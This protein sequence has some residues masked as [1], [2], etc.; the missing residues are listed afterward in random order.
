MP[1]MHQEKYLTNLNP[2]S[3]IPMD[4]LSKIALLHGFHLDSSLVLITIS[5]PQNYLA[6]D[7]LTVS[8]S[9][10]TSPGE[11]LSPSF[12]SHLAMFPCKKLNTYFDTT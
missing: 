7:K 3:T 5:E 12:F 9:Q 11:T 1:P 4:N 8:T 10:R 6:V 2:F